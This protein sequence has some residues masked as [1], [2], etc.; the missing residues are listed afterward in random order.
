MRREDPKDYADAVKFDRYLRGAGRKVPIRRVLKGRPYLHRSLKPLD[1][2]VREYEN[3]IAS[4]EAAGQFQNEC[5]G[6]CGT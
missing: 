6:L 1:T 5:E 2:A 3:G 4:S